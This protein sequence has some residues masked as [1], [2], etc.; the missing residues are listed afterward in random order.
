MD[1]VWQAAPKALILCATAIYAVGV[2]R[3]WS[4]AG[5][6][7]GITRPQVASFFAASLL[8]GAVVGWPLDEAAHERF[9]AHMLQHVAL[10]QAAAFLAAMGDP[11]QA[12]IMALPQKTVRR[13]G[14]DSRSVR[15]LWRGHRRFAWVVPVNYV[16]MVWLWHLP[17]LYDVA[18]RSEAV[19]FAE[20]AAL[21]AAGVL[22][23][24]QAL[25]DA[26]KTTHRLIQAI[27]RL[28][29]VMLATMPLSVFLT[30]ATINLYSSHT[31]VDASSQARLLAEQ[32]LGGLIML[33]PAGMFYIA[34]ILWLGWRVFEPPTI[35]AAS[36]RS[37]N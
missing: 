17:G 27:V 19:H 13:I 33:M 31:N 3:L 11:A 2:W 35:H 9:D 12:V 7:K 25:R 37:H 18:V 30:F 15:S 23:W 4:R 16:S 32:Q 36:G 29:A 24:R 20:H 22:L 5:I 26:R 1:E 28:T 34:I 10:M 14:R 8:A 21:F 6:G